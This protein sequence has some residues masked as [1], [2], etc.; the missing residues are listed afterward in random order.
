MMV[1]GSRARKC[2]APTTSRGRRWAGRS[3][4]TPWLSPGWISRRRT[5]AIVSTCVSRSQADISLRHQLALRGSRTPTILLDGAPVPPS[6][7][8]WFVDKSIA[9]VALPDMAAG[10]HELVLEIRYHRKSNPEWCYLLG[11]FGVRIEGRQARI[12]EPVRML[13][14][15]DWTSQG[16]PFYAGNVTYHCGPVDIAAGPVLRATKFAAPLL[17]VDIDGVRHGTIAFAPYEL[18]LGAAAP[19][20]TNWRSPPTAAASTPSAPC[21][22]GTTTNAGMARAPGAAPATAGPT[23]TT[24]AAPAFWSRHG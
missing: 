6:A 4:W 22:T 11:D 2:F 13:G 24:S 5:P 9:T 20:A 8:G 15:G 19:A 21:T 3:A 17:A 12:V 1:H 18:D 23:S 7:T 10:R 14:F 16:L